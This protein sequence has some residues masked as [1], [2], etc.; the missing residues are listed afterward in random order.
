M[1]VILNIGYKN[2][3][4]RPGVNPRLL[5]LLKWHNTVQD[6]FPL[7]HLLSETVSQPLPPPFISSPYERCGLALMVSRW[8][9]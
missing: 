6:A 4:T 8:S 7:S 3:L 2:S 5:I 9:G 1:V